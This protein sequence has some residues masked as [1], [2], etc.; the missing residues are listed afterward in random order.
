MKKIFIFSIILLTITLSAQIPVSLDNKLIITDNYLSYRPT[1]LDPIIKTHRAIDIPCNIYGDAVY[2]IK[3]GIVLKVYNDCFY[4]LNDDGT[5]HVYGHA[6]TALAKDSIIK[7]NDIIAQTIAYQSPYPHL[8]L[9]YLSA[10]VSFT[11]PLQNF[12]NSILDYLQKPRIFWLTDKDTLSKSNKIKFIPTGAP[13]ASVSKEIFADTYI[14]NGG[15][16][17]IFAPAC[18]TSAIYNTNTQTVIFDSTYSINHKK[19]FADSNKSVPKPLL[20]QIFTYGCIVDG[21][22]YCQTDYTENAV[23]NQY[24][25]PNNNVLNGLYTNSYDVEAPFSMYLFTNRDTTGAWYDETDN[26]NVSKDIFW[27]TNMKRDLPGFYANPS[28]SD[29]F[30]QTNGEAK[31]QD[32]IHWV[33][34]YATNYPTTDISN[35]LH[36]SINSVH[37]ILDNNSPVVEAATAN[38]TKLW[39]D[40]DENENKA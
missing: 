6:L 13:Y 31:Y 32:G 15:I 36:V 35:V 14:V 30:A 4:I 7:I 37:V 11:D 9:Q 20:S 23:E 21:K 24:I 19:V 25:D 16:T 8:D 1:N 39:I 27:S 2:A 34:V 18:Y 38:R 22:Q 28:N 40:G 17:A 12:D 5:Y 33:K 26:L 10:D 29:N 3:N